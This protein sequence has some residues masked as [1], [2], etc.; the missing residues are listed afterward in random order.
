M[1]QRNENHEKKNETES[2][3]KEVDLKERY[4]IEKC[5]EIA[6]SIQPQT[7]LRRPSRQPGGLRRDLRQ[8]EHCC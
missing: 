1:D 5:I 8:G 3:T 2:N 7:G 6:G 4:K